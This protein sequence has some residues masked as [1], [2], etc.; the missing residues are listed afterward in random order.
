METQFCSLNPYRRSSCCCWRW[1]YLKWKQISTPSQIKSK[2]SASPRE[3]MIEKVFQKQ[4]AETKSVQ[5]NSKWFQL[6]WSNWIWSSY[7]EYIDI[8]TY[9]ESK[10]TPRDTI[11]TDVL[12]FIDKLLGTTTITPTRK[13]SEWMD[14]RRSLARNQ[15]SMRRRKGPGT[16]STFNFV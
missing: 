2:K 15:W 13:A 11:H 1:Q 16:I 14:V 5:T 8:C 3:V 6:I 12:K 7:L 10:E 9:I 4:I